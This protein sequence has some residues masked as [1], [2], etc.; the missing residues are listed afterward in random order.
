MIQ[1]IYDDI[2]AQFNYG[3]MI[4]RIILVNIFV[5]LLV[6]II[7]AFSPPDTGIFKAFFNNLAL[8]SEGWTILKKPWTLLTHMITHQGFWHMGWNML[9]LY[10]FGRITG[11]LAGDRRILP[12]YIL[13]GL[14]GA[15]TFYMYAQIIDLTGGI[16]FGA[17]AAVTSIIVAAA[18]L[19]PDYIIRLLFLGD[20]KLKYI[21]LALIIIDVAMISSR[22]NTGG[23]LAH[24]G[25]AAL[26]GIFV[27]FLRRGI[28]ITESI[29]NLLYRRSK[30][31]NRR[32]SVSMTVV[33][34]KKQKWKERPRNQRTED[35][36][37]RIDQILDKINESG[38]NS[39]SEE[40]KDF[41]YK[42]S[43]QE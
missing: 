3:N 21:A 18:F 16:A 10:W 4:T 27:H 25:G 29:Q 34:N 8:S 9:M 6:I 23:H 35:T 33:E 30:K 2:K 36:Q 42:V 38:Y 41:L 24:L 14:A 17:S 12:L 31:K 5:F 15:L 39:L 7:K 32:S 37:E 1:S 13:G 20:V 19:A 40:E 28:D 26:G 43:K 11:D 22:D